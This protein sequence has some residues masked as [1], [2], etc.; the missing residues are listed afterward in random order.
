MD[1]DSYNQIKEFKFC[2]EY[3]PREI[4]LDEIAS[5]AIWSSSN[6]HDTKIIKNSIEELRPNIIFCGLNFS[7][8]GIL[9]FEN[10]NWTSWKNFHST[11]KMDTRLY[12]VLNDSKYRGAYMTD[13]IKCVPTKSAKELKN[14]IECGKINMNAQ[15]NI[16]KDE[17]KVLNNNNIEIYLMGRDTESY[18]K[19]YFYEFIKDKIKIYKY[20]LHPSPETRLDDVAFYERI[21]EQLGII[22]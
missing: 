14:K 3:Y 2:T 16:F 4:R 10:P 22:N 19:N 12:K 17:I 21:S 15:V 18:F 20:I 1:I 6:L 8:K 7:G 5:W 13:I 11:S 9:D